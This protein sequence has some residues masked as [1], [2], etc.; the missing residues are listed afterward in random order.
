MPYSRSCCLSMLCIQAPSCGLTLFLLRGHC[1]LL[2]FC[3]WCMVAC[4]SPPDERCNPGCC[5]P[6]G[7]AP[8]GLPV[9]S[10]RR[11]RC[12]LSWARTGGAGR[13]V[14][15]LGLGARC[16]FISNTISF[17]EDARLCREQPRALRPAAAAVR[18]SRVLTLW[19]L[20]FLLPA[21]SRRHSR[22]TSALATADSVGPSGEHVFMHACL[23]RIVTLVPILF[24]SSWHGCTSYFPPAVCFCFF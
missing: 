21:A 20:P 17:H 3:T 16:P 22:S 9:H 24:T 8:D 15:R 18:G 10:P 2:R 11:P 7:V 4:A 14:H 12:L 19:V 5:R 23:T 13:W 1:G 6:S